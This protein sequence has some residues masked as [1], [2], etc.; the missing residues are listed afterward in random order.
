M[1]SRLGPRRN[2]A[3]R[4]HN[5]AINPRHPSIARSGHSA[6]Q[7]YCRNRQA[8]CRERG[9]TSSSATLSGF[10]YMCTR[11]ALTTERI[12]TLS[13]PRLSLPLTHR[14]DERHPRSLQLILV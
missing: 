13:Y 1:L 9:D 8:Y 12:I 5:P 7:A 10:L 2:P 14:Y 11:S 6:G 4:R 3:I